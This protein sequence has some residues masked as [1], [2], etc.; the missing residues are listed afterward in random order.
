MAPRSTNSSIR[1]P[2]FT[3][4]L[5]AKNRQMKPAFALIM[6]CFILDANGALEVLTNFFLDWLQC[7]HYVCIF[8]VCGAKEKIKLF[9]TP[10]TFPPGTFQSIFILL[11]PINPL[12]PPLHGQIYTHIQKEEVGESNSLPC[13]TPNQ[14][15]FCCLN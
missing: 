7:S 4:P 9:F 5:Q 3:L 12:P 8:S 2:A 13:T 11:T 15:G 10:S 14:P 1:V 6:C